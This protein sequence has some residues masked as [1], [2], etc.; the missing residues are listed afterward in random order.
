MLLLRDIR[1]QNVG[2]LEF[3]LSTSLNVKFNGAVG[4]PIYD[5]LLVSI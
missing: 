3:D 5:F 1:L 2:D 4:L